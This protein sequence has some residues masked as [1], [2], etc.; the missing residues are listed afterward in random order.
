MEELNENYYEVE[1]HKRKVFLDLPSQIGVSVYSYAKLQMIEFWEFLNAHL[2]QESYQLMEMDTDSIYL[3]VTSK[4]IDDCVKPEMRE[5]WLRD[6]S[7]FFSSTDTTTMLDFEGHQISTAQWD[8]R[9]PGKFKIEFAGDGMICLSSK[10]YHCWNRSGDCKTSCKGVQKAR[11]E[12][13]GLDATKSDEERQE[14]NNTIISHFKS[15]LDSQKPVSIKNAGFITEK[16]DGGPVIKTYQQTKVGM[17]YFYP[18]RIVLEDGVS[19]APLA[20]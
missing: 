10:L 17:S 1:K 15:V 16:G 4:S 6:K 18:K 5:S 14:R 8:K 19:T 20:I 11:N 7:N 9:T 12:L 2:R 3:A 13:E